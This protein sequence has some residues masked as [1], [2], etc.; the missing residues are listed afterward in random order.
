MV[1]VAVGVGMSAGV[2][3]TWMT[4][5][6][7]GGRVAIGAAGIGA[8]AARIN[9]R[10]KEIYFISDCT[11]IQRVSILNDIVHHSLSE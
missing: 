7:G 2:S 10:M 9:K 6:F 4:A 3:V 5:T 11:S 1:G 8:Q